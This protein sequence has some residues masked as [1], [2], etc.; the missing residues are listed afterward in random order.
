MLNFFLQNF[1]IEPLAILHFFLQDLKV[2]PLHL[3][4]RRRQYFRCDP[5]AYKQSLSMHKSCER[6][7]QFIY[8]FYIYNFVKKIK[9][10][11]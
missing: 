9:K 10:C 4:V 2:L 1:R 7:L 5:L 3:R 6:L 8:I 11:I